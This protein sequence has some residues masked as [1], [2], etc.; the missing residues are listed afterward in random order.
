VAEAFDGVVVQ[1]DVRDH[2]TGVFERFAI[3]R[4]AVVLAGD[5]DPAGVEVLDRLLAAA[6]AELQLERRGAHRAGEQ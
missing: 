4:E 1:V 3:D 5:L 6:M 2:T